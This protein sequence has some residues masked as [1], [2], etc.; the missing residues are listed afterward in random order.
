MGKWKFH[1]E[2]NDEL[3][4]DL[5]AGLYTLHTGGLPVEFHL[6]CTIHFQITKDINATSR[7]LN[8]PRVSYTRFGCSLLPEGPE[9]TKAV[10]WLSVAEYIQLHFKT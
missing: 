5:Y 8:H 4:I 9:L 3:S 2:I 6:I 7:M 10:N 1:K